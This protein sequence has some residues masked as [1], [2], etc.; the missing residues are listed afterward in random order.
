[1]FMEDHTPEQCDITISVS[2]SYMLTGGYLSLVVIIR[3]VVS[4]FHSHPWKPFLIPGQY[5]RRGGIN[6]NGGKVPVYI[7][8]LKIP[9]FV[10]NFFQNLM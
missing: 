7:D 5:G 1:M 9:G 4:G 2:S 3:T 6:S 10:P 8:F